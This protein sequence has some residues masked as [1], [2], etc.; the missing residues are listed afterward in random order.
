MQGETDTP[1]GNVL[2]K[3]EGV[4]QRNGM[5]MALCPAHGDTKTR[6]LYVTTGEAGRVLIDCKKGCTVDEVASSIGLELA[7]LFPKSET[8]GNHRPAA[9]IRPKAIHESAHEIM[10]EH[11]EVHA[12]HIRKELEG[13]E[14]TFEWRQPN[15][16][17]GL[18]GKKMDSLPLYGSERLPK[19]RANGKR[20][21][22]CEGEKAADALRSVGIPALGTVCG[23]SST[24]SVETLRSLEGLS[25]VLWPDADPQGRDHMDR[26][27]KLL[28][29]PCIQARRF[30]WKEAPKK[31]DA[32]DHPFVISR[33]RENV[34]E[35][36]SLLK[37]ASPYAPIYNPRT[38]G[39]AGLSATR[40]K[41]EAYLRHAVAGGGVT[42]I[43]TMIG[44]L[45]RKMGGLRKGESIVVG[46]D[47]R[48]GK[49][50]FVGQIAVNVAQENHKVLLQSTEMSR[51]G[52][53]KRFAFARAGIPFAQDGSFKLTESHAKL[54]LA[55]H[56]EIEQMPLTIDDWNGDIDRIKANI[57]KDQP[58]LVIIDHL[59]RMKPKAD[60]G[61]KYMDIGKASRDITALKTEYDLP[62]L[63]A[64]QLSRAPSHR[65]DK[66][67][68][69]YDLKDAS[70]IEQDADI[71]LMLHRPGFY[72][73]EHDHNEVEVYCRKYRDG[74]PFKMVLHQL[75]HQAWF[76][77]S[78][79]EAAKRAHLSVVSY[80]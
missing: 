76:T 10:D 55:A 65:P 1:L 28:T 60:S 61:S 19:I 77:E 2:S 18:G 13:G 23:A 27:G 9:P 4:R 38:D 70:D 30:D 37:S 59:H 11:G 44:E 42:G 16:R 22:L 45:D 57:E 73:E 71:V 56:E 41:F 43:R 47:T 14:K 79:A 40:P 78:R 51:V 46:A 39:S 62:I 21:V 68:Q 32:A 50:I 24:P 74:E 3:L 52:Y 25:V 26:I 63:V 67:P 53:S 29:K 80:D 72:S 48:V 36:A 35:L 64:A 6:H 33:S 15:G 5:N 20:L 7:D 49:S 31:G 58:D 12:V 54:L 66:A 34:R 75:D 69:L 8:N 17:V